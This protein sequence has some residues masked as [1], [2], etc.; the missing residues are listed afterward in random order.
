MAQSLDD[1]I[2]DETSDESEAHPRM[3]LPPLRADLAMR[4]LQEPPATEADAH[5]PGSGKIET[6]KEMRRRLLIAWPLTILL[7]AGLVVVGV[8]NN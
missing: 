5:I 1:T 3:P 2:W 6:P 7:V 8:I 4:F